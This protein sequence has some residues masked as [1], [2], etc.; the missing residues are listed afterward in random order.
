MYLPVAEFTGRRFS[1]IPGAGAV[2]VTGNRLPYAPEQLATIGVGY[3]HERGV[4]VL[5]EAVHTG[6]QF[7]D[8]LNTVAAT[9]DGQRGLIP[10]STVWNTSVNYTRGR[11]TVFVAVK[12]LFDELFIV[13]RTRG[14]LPGH[15]RLVQAGVRLGF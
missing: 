15:S 8:D 3:S 14:I 4:D 9:P 10:A 1:S 13:D 7:G 2:S 6:D 12:N 5:L 11:A